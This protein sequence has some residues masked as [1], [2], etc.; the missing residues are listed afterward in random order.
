M[1]H[2]FRYLHGI[3]ISVLALPLVMLAGILFLCAFLFVLLNYAISSTVVFLYGS[4]LAP[5]VHNGEN[6]RNPLARISEKI[7]NLSFERV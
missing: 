1:G 6:L 5:K 3:L 2:T 4:P 7:I